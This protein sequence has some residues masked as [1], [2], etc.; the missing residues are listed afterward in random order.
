[1]H[2]SFADLGV[3]TRCQR[4]AR[5]PRHRGAVRRPA[6]WSSATSS[7]A[8]TCSSSPRPAPA[9]RSPSGSR[10]SSAS[11]PPTDRARPRSMLAPT[12]ELASQIADEL[13]R[14]RAGARRC[15][16]P[17][18]T[19]AS[20]SPSRR[21][22]P[23]RAH[24]LV[25]TPGRL[26][27]LLERARVHARRGAHTRARRGR[28]HARHG[29]SPGGRPD[30]PRAA[31]RTRQTLFFSATLDGRR[32]RARRRYTR[33][34]VPPRARRSRAE[35][36]RD[37]EHRF[38]PVADERRRRGA[39]RRARPPSATSRSCSCAPSAARTAS[40]SGS[41]RTA[42]SASRSTATSPS[43]SASGRSR[44]SSPAR[45]TRSSR[46]TSRPAGID[47]DGISHVINFDPPADHDAY[48]HRIGRTG[49]RGRQRGR[50]SRS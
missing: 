4:R 7:P 35:R 47:V 44:A 2:Q 16:S 13:R 3:S 37:V 14:H 36:A 8:A 49:A 42:C 18:S 22:R 29:L 39:G 46:P 1:M 15:A 34:A 20:A 26:E 11:S 32:R 24:I 28:P 23:A 48:M 31:P 10:W 30:R 5:A 40:S 17:P 38:V 9:R 25:A 33:D 45:S 50:A 12:R 19:A 21:R 43:A 41:T 27:D 6:A